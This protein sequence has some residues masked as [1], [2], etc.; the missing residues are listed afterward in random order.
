MKTNA[1]TLW[2]SQ[3]YRTGQSKHGGVSN[4]VIQGRVEPDQKRADP[5]EINRSTPWELPPV[6]SHF[7]HAGFPGSPSK[8]QIKLPSCKFMTIS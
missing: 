2:V 5:M 6:N 7:R 8:S 1:E 3:I 4:N